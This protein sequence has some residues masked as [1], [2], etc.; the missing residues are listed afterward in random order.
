MTVHVSCSYTIYN[1]RY[2]RTT[3]SIIRTFMISMVAPFHME[4][5]EGLSEEGGRWQWV[6]G[7][8]NVGVF[9]SVSPESV[10]RV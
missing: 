6:G 9:G 3:A 2:D 8:G 1:P 7:L 5:L 4:K 10:S